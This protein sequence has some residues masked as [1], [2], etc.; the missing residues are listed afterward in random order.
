MSITS[1]DTQLDNELR[2]ILGDEDYKYT[3]KPYRL[4]HLI[5]LHTQKAVKEAKRESAKWLQKKLTRYGDGKIA[6][7]NGEATVNISDI[8]SELSGEK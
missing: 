4:M 1:E 3:D 7:H 2:R 5:T 6:Y 8:L